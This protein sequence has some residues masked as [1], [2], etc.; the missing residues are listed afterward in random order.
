MGGIFSEEHLLNSPPPIPPT[1]LLP[2][3]CWVYLKVAGE[4]R[5]AILNRVGPTPEFLVHQVLGSR[6]YNPACP[7]VLLGTICVREHRENLW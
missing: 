1:S 6:G 3:S 2:L 5:E 7:Q 4:G